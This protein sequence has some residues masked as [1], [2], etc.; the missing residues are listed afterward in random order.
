MARHGVLGHELAK[1]L[2]VNETTVSHWK[3]GRK[4]PSLKR[5]D[6]IALAITKLSRLGEVVKGVDLLE[7][8]K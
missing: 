1:A 4:Q 3:T 5:L 6:A 8:I 7:E 2:D